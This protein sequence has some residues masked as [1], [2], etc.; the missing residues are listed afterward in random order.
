[1]LAL[2][3]VGGHPSEA[4]KDGA[5]VRRWQSQMEQGGPAPG[6]EFWTPRG[7]SEFLAI[8]TGPAGQ[9]LMWNPG[10]WGGAPSDRYKVALGPQCP[11]SNRKP[12]DTQH[13]EANPQATLL[14]HASRLLVCLVT[15][16]HKNYN[17]VSCALGS[18]LFIVPWGTIR[19]LKSRWTQT[20]WWFAAEVKQWARFFKNR[21]YI[22]CTSKPC[23]PLCTK[24]DKMD[25]VSQYF[26]QIQLSKWF[27]WHSNHRKVE[28]ERRLKN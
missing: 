16:I 8:L 6:A 9:L 22:H 1:M 28:H 23:S 14:L 13:L 21:K 11:D 10:M 7:Q 3:G 12:R 27:S 26:F 25:N 2:S 17:P 18:M 5:I 4:V 20:L 19:I 24:W 15:E